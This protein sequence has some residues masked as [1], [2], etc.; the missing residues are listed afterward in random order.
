MRSLSV[1]LAVLCGLSFAQN[2]FGQAEVGNHG[3]PFRKEWRRQVLKTREILKKM[4]PERL[5][6][7]A[8]PEAVEWLTVTKGPAGESAFAL[9]EADLAAS[10]LVFV[11]GHNTDKTCAQ[12]DRT[13]KAAIRISKLDCGK[14]PAHKIW[15]VLIGDVAHHFDLGDDMTDYISLAIVEGYRFYAET[16]PTF[17]LKNRYR[18][19]FHGLPTILEINTKTAKLSRLHGGLNM[20]VSSLPGLSGVVGEG[21]GANKNSSSDGYANWLESIGLRG[22]TENATRGELATMRR[23]RTQNDYITITIRID[24]VTDSILLEGCQPEGREGGDHFAI[25]MVYFA[26]TP[27][28]IEAQRLQKNSSELAALLTAPGW[29]D[30]AED[31]ALNLLAAG[32]EPG[33]IQEALSHALHLRAWRLVDT[34]ASML[35]GDTKFG[36]RFIYWAMDQHDAQLLEKT[37]LHPALK[38]RHDLKAE[39]NSRTAVGEILRSL[40]DTGAGPSFWQREASHAAMLTVLFQA[41]IDPA[42]KITNII[43]TPRQALSSAVAHVTVS[44]AIVKAILEKLPAGAVMQPDERDRT[45]V[46]YMSLFWN[47]TKDHCHAAALSDEA[48]ENLKGVLARYDEV[49]NMLLAAGHDGKR[50]GCIY[51]DRTNINRPVC[52]WDDSTKRFSLSLRTEFNT[53]PR[54]WAP[55]STISGNWDICG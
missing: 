47:L 12:T 10:E 17:A 40:Y 54:N 1:V 19:L 20:D 3:D 4:S 37:L 31:R 38:T 51:Y 52:H 48:K 27:E 36:G 43:N 5:L 26:P 6:P 35:P 55:G 30:A 11:E 14:L 18:G 23:Y 46:D 34:T 53:K 16:D 24:P 25:A 7:S 44:P 28:E 39:R 50:R 33:S 42:A 8:S 2:G 49:W 29:N 32:V 13:A 45:A 15:E 41:G 9:M 22:D 21:S